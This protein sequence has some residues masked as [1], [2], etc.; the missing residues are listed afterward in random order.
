MNKYQVRK[1]T[2]LDL[3]KNNDFDILYP[4]QVILFFGRNGSLD[5][6]CFC[7]LD[8][9]EDSARLS[10]SVKKVNLASFSDK[11]VE[12]I[13]AIIGIVKDLVIS[14]RSLATVSTYIKK[15]MQFL[16]WADKNDTLDCFESVENARPML[17]TVIN[18]SDDFTVKAPNHHKAELGERDFLVSSKMWIDLDDVRLAGKAEAGFKRVEP[19]AVF[20]IM[21]TGLIY[22]CLEVNSNE[23]GEIVSVVVKVVTDKKPKV[24]IHGLSVKEAISV[25]VYEPDVI[26]SDDVNPDDYIKVKKA[27]CEPL[28]LNTEGT[29]QAVR[30]GWVVV[31][32]NNPNRFVLTTGLKSSI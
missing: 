30:Y 14:G 12:Y 13:K 32:R 18:G 1:T 24:A 11:R 28:A 17:M 29:F 22:E 31:D 26:P 25:D 3:T 19:G 21:Y 27:F 6:G 10:N 15:F 9:S 16:D 4:E 5:L 7:Y 8:R 20:R 23:K 2:I